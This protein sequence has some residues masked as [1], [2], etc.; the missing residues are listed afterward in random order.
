MGAGE[1]E[2]MSTV[3]AACLVWGR[4]CPFICFREVWYM[5][6]VAVIMGSDSD[7]PQVKAAC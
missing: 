3:W 6:K 1:P 4:V 5:K 7:W 2:A